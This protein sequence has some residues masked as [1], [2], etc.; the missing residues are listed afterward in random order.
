MNTKNKPLF[1]AIEGGDGSG[2]STIIQKIKEK[3][4]DDVV[5][6]REPGGSPYAEAIRTLALKNEHAGQAD[7]KT[8]MCLMFAARYDHIKNVIIP[9]IT[10]GKHVI[11]DRFDASTFA[12]QIHAQKGGAELEKLFWTLRDNLDITPDWYLYA[13]VETKE[14]LERVKTRN[15]T[16]LDS[17]HFDEQDL[18]F[19]NRLRTGYEV[20]FKSDGVKSIRI[21]AN[22]DLENV[23]E[24]VSRIINS[25]VG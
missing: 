3:L 15:G 9:A 18:A 8:M 10:S 5:I 12:Y 14:G 2:K 23:H 16:N 4:G 7:H 11:T 25:L 24:Q 22:K 1:I 13:D 20:F 19:H 6:T 21:D 17:N